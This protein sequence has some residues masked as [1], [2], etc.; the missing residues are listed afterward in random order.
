MTFAVIAENRGAGNAHDIALDD[1]I[2]DGFV[3]PGAGVNLRVTN[4][5]GLPL[6]FTGDLFGTPVVVH[7]FVTP[8]HPTS[9]ANL[10]VVR[11][12]LEV[13]ADVRA[14]VLP[15]AGPLL[16]SPANQRTKLH[17]RPRP[18]SRHVHIDDVVG[19]TP[20]NAVPP[21]NHRRFATYRTAS[22]PEGTHP[23]TIVTVTVP[24]DSRSPPSRPDRVAGLSFT[25]ARRR[26]VANPGRMQRSRSDTNNADSDDAAM[27]RSRS[28][29]R[30]IL[31]ASPPI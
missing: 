15:T 16:G 11:Y 18:A 5:A 2:P 4:G 8:F 12:D 17:L 24:A 6:D 31:A 28:T 14:K 10:V 3:I 13:A 27:T 29:T 20:A 21:R 1:Q 25:G 7:D 30:S 26:V 23:G 22:L 9:G 19:A